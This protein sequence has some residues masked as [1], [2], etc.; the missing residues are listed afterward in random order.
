MLNPPLN[1][2]KKKKNNYKESRTN[3]KF[4]TPLTCNRI[5][6]YQRNMPNLTSWVEL[7]KLVGFVDTLRDVLYMNC[8]FWFRLTLITLTCTNPKYDI[9]IVYTF[10]RVVQLAQRPNG[11]FNSWTTIYIYMNTH[12][13]M[14]SLQRDHKRQRSQK[15][16]EKSS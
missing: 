3:L 6:K 8:I 7:G 10:K 4:I 11:L 1:F 2:I 5:L 13:H 16:R 12:T 14:S 9:F 15:S